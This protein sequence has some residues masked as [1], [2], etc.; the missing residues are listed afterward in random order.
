[1]FKKILT[2]AISIYAAVLH[3]GQFTFMP[4]E[5]VKFYIWHLTLGL[6]LVF[7]HKPM[8]KDAPKKMLALDW[9][10]VLITFAAGGFLIGGYDRYILIMQTGNPSQDFLILAVAVTLLSLEAARRTLGIVLPLI[11]VATIFYALFGG[12]L[13]GLLAHRGYGLIRVIS[14]SVSDQGIYGTP[15]AVCASNIYL[16]LLFAS[17]LKASGADKIF[18]NIAIALTGRKRGGPAK[19]AV[20]TSCLFG[21]ISGSAVANVMSTGSFTI[22]LMK[23]MGY[24]KRFAAGV[25]AVA[26]TGGQFMPPIMGA[27]AFIV[28]DFTGIPYAQVCIAALLPSLMYYLT[29]F[30]M[31]D[32][33]S[34][35]HNLQGLSSQ[36]LPDI[37]KELK[38][39]FKLIVALFVLL[40]FLFWFKT[41]PMLS[42]IYSIAALFV[43]AI[44]DKNERL[45]LKKM[46]E[47]CV[48]AGRSLVPVVS[49][50]AASGI[51]T[52]ML[53]I[54]GL[55]LKFS[56][57]IVDLGGAS[58]VLCL[59][60]AMLVCLILGMGLPAT[61]AYVICA[62][63]IAPAL[64]KIGIPSLAAHLFLLYYASISAITPPV[65]V[66]SYAAAGIAGE[67][68]MKV[69]MTAVKLAISGFALPFVFVLNADYLHL[70]FD[71]K[72]LFTY[73]SAF[74][75]C[76]SLSIA[77]QGWTDRKISVFERLIYAGIIATAIQSGYLI[78]A[79]GI[80]VFV[81]LF[82]RRA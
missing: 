26:S 15:I 18:Q 35:K 63:A 32:L 64:I 25:E 22:P 46:V 27:A 31:V 3:I 54:T 20:I 74:A 9:L 79:I 80:G 40:L 47:V 38:R 45:N 7:I 57:F 41:T 30:K 44:V 17:L 24:K 68:A 67:N 8:I 76:Y 65:A 16:F 34:A 14:A 19:M 48:D 56:S 2:A 21:S 75:V 66:A 71:L 53:S 4:M 50:C 43:C 77:V 55:G 72:T 49:A 51:V 60:L 11:A 6:A 5:S 12:S 36:D 13:P 1:M 81:F 78:S 61:A 58:I 10:L 33:E 73:A 29:L 69:G 39:S 23:T 82:F 62:A 28:S 70:G 59:I 42:V 52:G 37:K